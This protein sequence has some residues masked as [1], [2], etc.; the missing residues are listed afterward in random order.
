MTGAPSYCK[1]VRMKEFDDVLE[2]M[3]RL[4]KDCP[5]DQKQTLDT[6]RTY[7]LEEAYECAEAIDRRDR[8]GTAP[9]IEELGDLLLQVV[10]QSEVLSET[11]KK[12]VIALVLKELKEKLVR[13]HPHVFGDV[14]VQNPDAALQQWND[15]KA[16]E[17]KSKGRNDG[18][19]KDL[20]KA[21]TSLQTARKIGEKAAQIKFDWET[22]DAAWKDVLSEVQE[23]SEATAPQH[24][25]EEFGDVLF[26]LVQWGRLRKIDSETALRRANS[27]FLSR[28]SDMERFAAEENRDISEMT[29]DE[30]NELWKRAKV[31]EKQQS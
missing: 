21:L 20:P 6:L 10:F 2:V 7:L 19:F 14:K 23:L 25:E 27:K 11:E 31:R 22:P 28:F 9:L 16:S 29:L 12:N 1:C 13:R 15:I 17:K 4:R 24:I 3:H 18:F 26:S 8:D 5:W 30:K